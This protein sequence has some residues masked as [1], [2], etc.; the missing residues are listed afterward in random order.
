MV[1][2]ENR[3]QQMSHRVFSYVQAKVK[4]VGPSGGYGQISVE[5]SVTCGGVELCGP[6]IGRKVSR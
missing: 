5:N 2:T 6:L 4:S 1:F 3:A